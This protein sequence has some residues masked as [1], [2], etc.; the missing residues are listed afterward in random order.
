M[1]VYIIDAFFLTFRTKSLKIEAE[2]QSND[3]HRHTKE[4][5]HRE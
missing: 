5:G 2:A 3:R 4:D 1:G